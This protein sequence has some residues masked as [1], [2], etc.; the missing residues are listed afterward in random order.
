MANTFKP[1]IG[2]ELKLNI[3]IDPLGE[4]TM[5]DYDFTV[6]VYCTVKKALVI[7][8]ADAIRIDENNYIVLVDSAIIGAGDVKCKVTAHIPDF[9]FPDTIRT[10]IVGIDTGIEVIRTI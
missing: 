8:K 4:L 6:E 10:E 3:H 5:D 7:N 9:D 1:F 2:T